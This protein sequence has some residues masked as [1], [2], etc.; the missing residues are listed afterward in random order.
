MEGL[1]SFSIDA[2]LSK[3]TSRDHPTRDSRPPSRGSMSSDDQRGSRSPSPGQ[4]TP[5]PGH[6]PP[7]PG[8]HVRERDVASRHVTVRC[9]A[10]VPSTLAA[11]PAMIPY[12]DAGPRLP[13][14]AVMPGSAFHTQGCAQQAFKIAQVQH[15]Q[16]LQLDWFARTG[17]Y[18]P[19]VIEFDGNGPM[20]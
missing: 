4:R 7:T 12:L 2:L 16:N 6:R 17:M 19:R 8:C 9:P 18:M 5:T 14:V 11:L 1:K 10:P 3:D 15:I 13:G 20:Y